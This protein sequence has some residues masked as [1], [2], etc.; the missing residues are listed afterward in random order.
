[1]GGG[2]QGGFRGGGKANENKGG[3]VKVK[4]DDG[5]KEGKV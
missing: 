4:M 3:E 5:R 2:G 1:M